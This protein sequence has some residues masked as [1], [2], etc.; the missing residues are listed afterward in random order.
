MTTIFKYTVEIHNNFELEL[1]EGSKFL[2][3]FMQFSQPRIWFEVD[4]ERPQVTRRFSIY[5]TG[6]TLPEIP[7]G[8]ERKHLATFPMND[9]Q[10]IWHLYEISEK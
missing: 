4:T 9:G 1:H 7:P 8:V 10:F 2:N 5:G 6:H 3:A